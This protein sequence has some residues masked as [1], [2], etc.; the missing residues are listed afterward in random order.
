MKA[1][2]LR[3]TNVGRS[4]GKHHRDR[5]GAKARR[6]RLEPLENR[7]LLSVFT[8]SNTSDSGTGS[9][10]QAILDANAATDSALIQFNVPTTDPRFVDVDSGLVGGDAAP[11]AFVIKPLSA[12]PAL[13]DGG[14]TIDGRTQTAF[15]GDT[16]PFGPEIVLNGSLTGGAN[17]LVFAS[18][19]NSIYGLNVQQFFH[20]I[21]F[22]N[23]ASDN[24][25]QGNYVGTDATGT[26]SMG[27]TGYGIQVWGTNSLRNLI[28]SE[29]GDPAKRN[30]VSGNVNTGVGIVVSGSTGNIIAGNYIGVDATGTHALGNA[31]RGI[32]E[33]AGLARIIGNVISGNLSDGILVN[34]AGDV[35]EGNYIGTDKSGSYVLGNSTGLSMNASSTQVVGN[36]ISGN[37]G[38]GIYSAASGVSNCVIQRNYIGTDATGTVDLGNG[39]RGIHIAGANAHGNLIGSLDGD[40]A[41]RNIISGNQERGIVISVSTSTANI[42]A[43]NYVGTDKTGS[44]PLGNGTH[45]VETSAGST[46]ITG[47][48]ISA[49]SGSGINIGNG[50]T[51]SVIQGNL[52]G[53]NATGSAALGNGGSGISVSGSASQ[54]NL[55]GSLNGDPALRNVISANG[56]GV[57]IA[58]STSTGNII[59]E[60]YIGTDASGAHALGNRGTGLQTRASS[61]QIVGNVVAANA[62]DGISF[63]NGVSNCVVQGNY[64]GTDA[65]GTTAFGNMGGAIN[66]WGTNSHGN[67]IG[68]E[69]GNPILRNVVCGSLSVPAVG[70]FQATSTGNV[71][72]G[73]YVG[74]DA[75]GRYALS[76]VRGVQINAASTRIIGNV[77][78]AS[79]R[80]GI[81]INSSDNVVQGNYIGTD[82]TGTSALG[83]GWETGNAWPALHVWPTGAERNLIGSTDGNPALRNVVSGNQGP[84]VGINQPGNIVAGNLIGTAVDGISP[85]GNGHT[86]VSVSSGGSQIVS[87]T[88]AFNGGAGVS[89]FSGTS[90]CIRENSI[91][92]NSGMGIDLDG[93]GVTLN[94][95][96]DADTG[97][98]N[99][100][101][102]PILRLAETGATTHVAGVLN[103]AANTTYTLDFY[104]NAA[105]DPSGYGEGQTWLVAIT[106][107]TDASGHVAFDQV[108]AAV[109]TA[110]QYITATATD[111]AG[112]TSEFSTFDTTAPTTTAA[113]AGTAGN[114]GWYTSAVTVTLTVSDPDP[115]D[116]V[117]PPTTYCTVDGSSPQTYT[118]PFAVSGDGVHGITYWSVDNVGNVET[119]SS[120]TINIDTTAPT[121]SV[122]IDPVSPA[123]TGWYNIS[124]GA[125]AVSFTY[126]DAT[127]GLAGTLPADYTAADGVNAA[128]SV[129]ICDAAGNSATVNI[130]ELKVDTVAP[131]V[132]LNTPPEG[133]SYRVYDTV[134]ADYGATD[135][136]SG[137]D[138][139]TGTVPNGSAIDTASLGDK[140]FTV[141]ATDVAGN[142]ATV[143]HNYEVYV[144]TNSA[145][146]GMVWVDFNDDGLVDFGEQGLA[147]VTVHLRGTDI[148][149]EAVDQV[150]TTDGDGA[151][152]FLNLRPG[153]YSITKEA[154]PAG[155]VDGQA[156]V[157]TAG[158][159]YDA[160][161]R[162]FEEISLQG[163]QLGVNYNF[164]E[165]PT[166]GSAVA[167][168]QTATIGFWQN[169][170][171]QALIKAFDDGGLNGTSTNLGNWLA[172]TL[173]NV[174]GAQAGANNLAGKTNAEVAAV[175]QQR[176]VVKGMKLDAQLMATALSVYATNLSL[177]G[178]WSARYGF[179]VGQY[180]LGDSTYNIRNSGLA[181]GVANNT[182][183]TVMDIL[184]SADDQA[185]DG[186][187][188]NGTTALRNMANTVFDGINNS[189][190]IS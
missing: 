90:N 68:S 111:P 102:F 167:H 76:N 110:G 181:F 144:T 43:G 81:L 42:I 118:A 190:D 188:Y 163:D 169:K 170:N 161:D 154:V 26:A 150:L 35:I 19:N 89:V 122:T 14:T 178:A 159:V 61:T 146:S 173:P 83:N 134:L 59:A 69:D 72:A 18:S 62:G 46:T 10:R 164:G 152:N 78:S 142:T 115:D 2:W 155:F 45:G 174:F 20:G 6:L 172:A 94:D 112:N 141:T 64:V 23:N 55:I 57:Y 105:A 5:L 160:V 82:A 113:L 138:S 58:Q 56:S 99:L 165:R 103:S 157:G 47:N 108:L 17:G 24:V 48:L 145:L 117:F 114:D 44:V 79:M 22:G 156:S 27:N 180:G 128:Y 121:L 51:Q 148:V 38:T 63:G 129:T 13:T 127:S 39:S 8:V 84:G 131:A 189:G 106:V 16:N 67:L 175:Y 133:A 91:Y 101:N 96:L 109:T 149:G 95:R 4:Y 32:L 123:A 92:S 176:F 116:A 93:M 88:I 54:S 140:T 184:L 151:F 143:T 153:D 31:Q 136:G 29:D 66:L 71:I 52:I 36:V 186:V 15:S 187:L 75:T 12:L 37:A 168:G 158:G 3:R 33:S 135:G 125:P 147:G 179:L 86:G 120:G 85:L 28:G 9:L 139:I 80:E 73:N 41:K 40:P 162:A 119:A 182:T 100:Q 104:A 50:V 30:V 137:I 87:N 49:N 77:I 53:T 98:N 171:G 65:A 126:G 107:T 11:D 7:R 97:A 177:G 34:G 25:V 166:A 21:G 124:T 1:S 70:I 60:N 74:I 185:V 130:P 183:M 132:T